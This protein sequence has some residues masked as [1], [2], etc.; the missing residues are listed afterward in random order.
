MD[1]GRNTTSIAE[2]CLDIIYLPIFRS[3]VRIDYSERIRC[4]K[5]VLT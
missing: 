2:E 5:P 3:K 4:I 1:L